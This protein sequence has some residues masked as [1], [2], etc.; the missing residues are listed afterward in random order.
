MREQQ[1]REQASEEV[2]GEI[3]WQSGERQLFFFGVCLRMAIFTRFIYYVNKLD[4]EVTLQ[5]LAKMAKES[6]Q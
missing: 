3:E 5:R 1:E 2:R 6:A 4:F